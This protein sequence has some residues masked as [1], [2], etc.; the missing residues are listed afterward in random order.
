MKRLCRAVL[1]MLVVAACGRDGAITEPTAPIA[2]PPGLLALG[3]DSTTGA[4]IETNKDD[5]V[6]GEVVHVVGRGWAPGETV[7]MFMTEDPD[8]HANVTMDVAADSTGAFSVHYY[9]VQVHDLGVTFTLTATGLTSNSVAVAVFTDA[10]PSV[11]SFTL[12]S[13]TFT[14]PAA[15]PNAPATN[16]ITVAPG[17]TVTMNVTATTIS[18]GSGGANW[19]STEVA[20]RLLPVDF[21]DTDV[22]DDFDV[23]TS[24]TVVTKSRSFTFVAPNAPGTYDVRARAFVGNG[25]SGSGGTLTYNGSL[26]VQ[27]PSNAAPTADA[28]GPYHG[29]EGSAIALDGTGSTDTDGSIASYAWTY[30][31]VSADA[32]ASCTITNP[33]S[34]SAS[35]TCNEDGSYT[36]TLVVTDDDGATDDETV[37]LTVTNA[38]PTANAGGP[39]SGAEGSTIQLSGSGNDPG[40]NDDAVLTYAWSVNATG[41]DAGGVCTL[42]SATAQNPTVT[43]TDDSGAGNFTVSLTVS[44]DDGGVSTASTVNLTVSNANPSA[45]AGGPYTGNEG[46]NVTLSGSKSDAG[47]NDTHTYKWTWV[48]QSGVD[49]GATCSFSDDT[50][51]SPTVSCTDDGVYKVTLTVTDDDAG[52]GSDDATLTLGNANPNVTINSPTVGQLFSLLNGA[53]SVNASYS[54]AGANDSHTCQLELDGALD[55]TVSYFA[56]SGG[57]C[58]GSILPDE[59]GVYTLTVRVK[60]DDNGEGSASVM[61]VVYDPSAGFVTGGGWIQSAAGAYK[62]DASLSG[63]ATFGF[64]SKYKKGATIP[65]G[66]TEFQFHAGG[67]NFHSVNYQW[68]VVN[69]AGTNAQFKGT[70]TINGQGSYT[71]MLWATDGG[72]SGDKFRMQITDD[73]NGDAT[74]YDNGVDQV[75]AGGSIVIHT[76]GKK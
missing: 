21:G 1:A 45:D 17:A 44:D 8:T 54:D 50:V 59:A 58:T 62:P 30:Q 31:I 60:D 63:K 69:Q 47:S 11:G 65:E 27:A 49:A 64:V 25:C 56:V 10:A 16:P 15:P 12:N 42:S 33:G 41:I 9:D 22:C 61:I 43:C 74:V 55:E 34:A 57:S 66:N 51:L 23:H 29:A 37:N 32:G 53:V 75:I 73:N 18:G 68:L 46:A 48:A 36:V 40:D 28:G 72:N 35:I 4:S 24:N 39:Y 67:M 71:F 76:G 70:G 3:V 5:Y 14:F 7:R 13:T 26:T 2:P 19:L 52:T 6:P 38:I 20:V